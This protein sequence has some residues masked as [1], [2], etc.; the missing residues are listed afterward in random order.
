MGETVQINDEDDTET[1]EDTEEN[2]AG[3]ENIA[4]IVEGA[5]AQ[6]MLLM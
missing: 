1:V 2:V 5:Q 3:E 6:G 4:E